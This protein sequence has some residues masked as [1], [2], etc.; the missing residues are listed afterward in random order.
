MLSVFCC[1]FITRFATYRGWTNKPTSRS[2][3]AILKS[4]VFKVFDNDGVFLSGC[5]VKMF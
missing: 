1:M 4:N 5:I 2:D 3:T